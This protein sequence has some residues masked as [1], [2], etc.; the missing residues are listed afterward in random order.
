VSRFVTSSVVRLLVL[1][2]VA[3]AAAAVLSFRTVYEPDLGWHLAHG[4]EN[5][6]GR[7]VRTN[8]FDAAH[9]DYPQPFTSWVWDSAAYA[10]WRIGG[11]TGV[12]VFQALLLFAAFILI[13]RASRIRGSPLP[14][15][16]IAIL[17]FLV[18]EPRAIP[19]PHVASFV[20]M[21]ACALLIERVLA[22]RSAT[23]LWWAVPVIVLWSNAHTESAFGVMFIAIVGLCE[24]VRPSALDRR[25]AV[26]VLAIAAVCAIGLLATPYGLGIFRYL[27]E[28]VEMTASLDI[29]ELRPAYLPVYRGFF[30]YLGVAAVLLVTQP[31]RLTLWEA[32]VALFFG[33]LGWRYLR[34][35]PLVFFA[36]AP[37][38]AARVTRLT[39][40][41]IDPRAVLA[42]VVAA[43]MLVART[44]VTTL[45]TELRVGD[46]FPESFFSARA[47]AL[48]RDRG[49]SGP[50]FNSNN[51]GG[52]LA[53]EL[54]PQVRIFQDSRMQAS[55]P[56]HIPRILDATTQSSWD[57][58][59][60]GVDWAVLSSPRPNQ[61]SGAGYFPA[62]AWAIVF[63]DEAVEVLVRRSGRYAALAAEREYQFVLPDSRVADLLPALSSPSRNRIIEEARRNRSD[64]PRGFVT[65]AI[66]CVTGD[67][68][69]CAD[70]DRLTEENPAFKDDEALVRIFRKD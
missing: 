49:L 19:R 70:V 64:N 65:A 4:R 18:L 16:A 37:M 7:I 63:W 59:V 10:S 53:W 5:L 20:G 68:Q 14:A 62:T 6:A 3:G 44:P 47:I 21:A 42:T 23:P 61:L 57:A 51:L 32:A 46:I 50:V 67:R 34:Q 31:R 35:T 25:E 30:V 66:F 28:N 39:E 9:P 38:L 27:R 58:L 36:T 13:Y 48:A 41:G 45:V 56:S 1:A 33:V 8:V 60:S 54:Y 2:L 52:W 22:R 40:L 29:A 26:R 12:Q 17:G 55:P 69:S 24:L 15:L 11:D 43:A